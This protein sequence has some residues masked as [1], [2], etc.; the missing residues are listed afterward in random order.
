MS[1]DEKSNHDYDLPLDFVYRRGVDYKKGEFGID[2]HKEIENLVISRVD[3][4]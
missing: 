4:R 2:D 3:N 1:I